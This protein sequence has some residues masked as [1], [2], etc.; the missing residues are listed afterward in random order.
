MLE[1]PSSK[2]WLAQEVHACVTRHLLL[3]LEASVSSCWTVTCLA[4]RNSA[5]ITHYLINT[6]WFIDSAATHTFMVVMFCTKWIISKHFLLSLIPFFAGF[7]RFWFFFGADIVPTT[8]KLFPVRIWKES[9]Y[10]LRRKLVICMP[11]MDAYDEVIMWKNLI[12]TIQA[13]EDLELAWLELTAAYMKGEIEFK[14]LLIRNTILPKWLKKKKSH[15]NFLF[16]W[17]WCPC[18]EWFLCCFDLW[19]YILR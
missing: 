8:R 19:S 11:C 7:L 2:Q 6:V 5:I 1:Q 14:F 15:A 17:W 3:F 9:P 12:S 16:E 10:L 13:T 4:S 18:Q